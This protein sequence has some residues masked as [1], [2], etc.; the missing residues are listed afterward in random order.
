CVP[1]SATGS[2]CRA[3]CD[4]G[5]PN[6]C[7]TPEICHPFVGDFSGRDYGLCYANNGYGDKCTGDAQCKKPGE[8][9]VP[10]DD[11]SAFDELSS[12]CQFNV[13][14]GAGLAPCAAVALN[15]GGTLSGD[16][17]CG[18][19]LCVGSTVPASSPYFCFASCVTD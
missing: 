6:S 12:I 4:P 16:K 7:P 3:Y 15:D 14:S 5:L 13:G 8:S 1:D 17:Q 18:S 9:C 10:F 2:S 11:P 19:G